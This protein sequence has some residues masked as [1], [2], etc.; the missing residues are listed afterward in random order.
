M[1]RNG[2]IALDSEYLSDAVRQTSGEF[3]NDPRHQPHFRSISQEDS[4]GETQIFREIYNRAMCIYGTVPDGMVSVI[5]PA[6]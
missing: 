1:I 4:R 6:Q 3:D 5:L 2:Y